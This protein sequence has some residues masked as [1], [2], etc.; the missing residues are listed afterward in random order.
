[1]D[2]SSANSESNFTG[3]CSIL[4][5]SFTSAFA[6]VYF[7]RVV[8]GIPGSVWIKNVQLAFIGVFLAGLVCVIQDLHAI[9]QNGFLHGYTP[10]VWI[11][12]A[13]QVIGGLIVAM[14]VK[15]ADNILKG[16]ATSVSIV[17]SCVLCSLLFQLELN[18]LFGL[19]ASCV[20]FAVLLYSHA[21]QYVKTNKVES[22][23]DDDSHMLK[24]S[25]VSKCTI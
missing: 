23:P 16:L 14:V 1:M 3:F 8:K 19:G 10:V 25:V 24:P 9:S 13:L 4:V 7:E 6:G 22:G 5:S 12:I 20:V 21:S 18:G 17:L 11:V 2:A 15:Y